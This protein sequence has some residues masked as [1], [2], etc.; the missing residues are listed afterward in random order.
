[1]R[2]TE[3]LLGATVHQ[4]LRIRIEMEDFQRAGGAVGDAVSVP[5]FGKREADR[6]PYRIALW[7]SI[8]HPDLNE[9]EAVFSLFKAR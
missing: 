7:M 8:L 6:F 1:M 5:H 9:G 2:K 3:Q 4:V